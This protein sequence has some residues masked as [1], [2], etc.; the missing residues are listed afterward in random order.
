M[1]KELKANAQKVGEETQYEIR[2]AIVRM[3]KKGMKGREIARILDVSE[4]HVSNV[5]KAYAENGIEGIKPK[6]QG[7]KT[8]EKRILSPQQEKEIMSIIVEK[9]PDQLCL[10]GCMWT[11][12]NIRDLIR[13][14]YGID[15]K[16][17]TL[18][19]YLARWGFSVQ[20]PVKRAYKQ[21]QKQIDKW[22]NEEFP[23]ITKRAEAENAEI[24]FGDE[25]N[26][27]N[28]ANYMKGYAPKGKTPVVRVEAQKFKI[29][30][31]SAISKRGKLRFMLYKENMDASKLIDFMGRLIRDTQKKVFLI[32]D[33]LRVHHSKKVQ[34]WLEKHKERIEVFYLP[35]Y[36]PEYNP[37]ELVNSDLKRAV[38]QKASPRSK[39]ELEKNVRSHL[40]SLQSDRPKI[41]SFFHA[42]STRY[43]AAL[44]S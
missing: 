17:S 21:D 40:K 3:L 39:E 15:M 11:R 42:P 29:N 37:D 2:K 4:G 41:S 23:G 33:N 10:K 36:A 43:A 24:F 28:T 22:L 9:D 34:E 7:R 20:R 12:N 19:Y 31:L 38:G 32:L 14:K 35:P 44:N 6:H 27:Q 13:E 18:G 25:T 16:L 30:M 5:K 1:E 26:I 8:G